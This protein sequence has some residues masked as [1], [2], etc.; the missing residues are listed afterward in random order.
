[1]SILSWTSGKKIL[2]RSAERLALT[3]TCIWR[4]RADVAGNVIAMGAAALLPLAAIVG[5]GVDI[6]RAYM[7]KARLQQACDA[8]ALAARRNMTAPKLTADDKAQAMKFFNFN[9]SEG[10]FG[11]TAFG[12]T[13]VD[14]K[15]TVVSKNEVSYTDGTDPRVVIGHARTTLNTT[16]MKI[17]DYESMVIEVNCASRLDVGNVDVV[18]VLDVTGSMGARVSGGGTRLTAL[19]DSVEEFYNVLGPGGNTSGNQIRYGFVPYSS[20]VNVG[21]LIYDE[22]PNWLLGSNEDDR[23]SYQTRRATWSTPPIT[24]NASRPHV[25]YEAANNLTGPECQNNF[26]TQNSAI[27]AVGLYPNPSG[28]PVITQSSSGGIITVVT[29]TYSYYSWYR[30]TLRNPPWWANRYRLQCRRKVSTVTETYNEPGPENTDV[31]QP[32]ATNF[33]GWQYGQFTHDVHAYVHSIKD[34]NPAAQVPTVNGLQLDRWDGCIEEVNTNSGI[35]SATSSIPDNAL[36][37]QMDH[38]PTDDDDASKWRP[39]WS[40]V[41]YHRNGS[42]MWDTYGWSA[43]P[44]KSRRL[45]EYASYDEG[46]SDDLQSYIDGLV[47]SGATNHAIGMAWGARL[48]SADGIFGEENSESSNGFQI[49]RHV[50]FMTDGYMTIHANNYDPWGLNYLDGRIGPTNS[51]RSSFQSRQS[52]RFQLMCSAV[53]SKGYTIWVIQFGVSSVTS[54]MASCASSP[55]HAQPATSREGLKSAFSAIAKSIGGLRIS[56]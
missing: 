22:N 39:F 47:A 41:I 13:V 12:T 46:T 4:L 25:Q 43:C 33:S 42:K 16:L 49:G 51:S 6:G 26:G 52:Q 19:Q 11:T 7:A 34:E 1:M 37:L 3:A 2:R 9:F 35:T 30:Y 53:K 27:P 10:V 48:L 21:E 29:K 8:G 15:G 5:G 17:F 18:M 44:T 38:I 28:N 50:V 36:D 31:W 54:N 55:G 14:S 20:A 45:A 23:W 32:N 40:D 56:K 24:S